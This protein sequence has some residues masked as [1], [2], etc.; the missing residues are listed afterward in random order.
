[1]LR[2]RG[3]TLVELIL[4][5]GMMLTIIVL[6]TLMLG[7]S[8]QAFNQTQVQAENQR[9]VR[10]FFN[11]VENEVSLA[12]YAELKRELPESFNESMRY[13]YI[14]N[15]QLMQK[16]PGIPPTV[17]M[18]GLNH[19]DMESELNMVCLEDNILRIE[20][21]R[22]TEDSTFNLNKEIHLLNLLG[23]IQGDTEGTVFAYHFNSDSK[24]MTS[25]SILKEHQIESVQNNW[26]INN[27]RINANIL[28]TEIWIALPSGIS[29]DDLIFTFSTTGS[30]VTIDGLKQESGVSSVD[31]SAE[32]ARPNYLVHAHDGS[33]KEYTLSYSILDNPPPEAR[34]VRISTLGRGYV[35]INEPVEGRYIYTSNGNGV[36]GDS[37][38]TWIIADDENGSNQSVIINESNLLTIPSLEAYNVEARKFI[39][40][41]VTP[42]ASNGNEGLPV[43]SDFV[44]IYPDLSPLWMKITDDIFFLNLDDDGRAQY[45]EN[46]KEDNPS[47]PDYEDD[48]L[49]M[50]RHDFNI[51]RGEGFP[52]G[53]NDIKFD[54]NFDDPDNPSLSVQGNRT[55]NSSAF[56]IDIG[57]FL[58]SQGL[59]NENYSLE[60]EAELKAGDPLI[61]S[62]WGLL[63]N[64]QRTITSS[65][66]FR[67]RDSGYTFQFDP[68]LSGTGG[69][70]D[71]FV[72]RAMRD[73]VHLNGEY[74]IQS[75]NTYL[76]NYLMNDAFRRGKIAEN[77]I[78]IG[79]GDRD[80]VHTDH[81]GKTYSTKLYVYDQPNR[82][83][84]LGAKT[85][86]VREDREETPWSNTMWF[87][88][89]GTIQCPNTNNTYHGNVL[90]PNTVMGSHNNEW[91][92]ILGFRIWQNAGDRRYHVKFH[93]IT[94]GK[95]INEK[96]TIESAKFLSPDI[97]AVEF[98]Q[99]I[100]DSVNL[101][102]GDEKKIFLSSD[103]IDILEAHRSIKNPK[104]LWLFLSEVPDDF[105]DVRVTIENSAVSHLWAGSQIENGVNFPVD[106]G[107]KIST[108]SSYYNISNNNRSIDISGGSTQDGANVI[109]WTKHNGDNQKW[110]FIPTG[111]E[112]IFFIESKSAEGKYLRG[113]H[114]DIIEIYNIKGPN[115][116]KFRNLDTFKWEINGGQIKNL[117]F[118]KYLAIENHWWHGNRLRLLDTS[119]NWTIEQ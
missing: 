96:L 79:W 37:L 46:R 112:N 93:N 22:K 35:W 38:Y 58:E 88:H 115:S 87:G 106:A 26:N 74:G 30:E 10:N 97:I 62:G 5:A 113:R 24:E 86:R 85:R 3:L 110:R 55:H 65:N 78:L 63:V 21:S 56:T 44:E 29:R 75:R 61:A 12:S 67:A 59:S 100:Q 31:L 13:L 69:N 108:L 70:D 82:G 2:K 47:L 40:L 101:G 49:V 99:E 72:I 76:A 36:E 43:R 4:T 51:Y 81:F 28:G 50:I 8:T 105:D 9:D 116:D 90:S 103:S 92:N 66:E 104:T 52:P 34:R 77:N 98:D 84:I 60:L 27:D 39:A 73:S 68:G 41:E 32:H 14:E 11:L 117:H 25:F 107:Q 54:V 83:L 57:R 45:N 19:I 15:N 42:I 16:L 18:T 48:V 7:V 119:F 53:N 20:I 23:Q 95:G 91:G 109:Q 118:S 94:L 71:G 6:A 89:E 102:E 17:L 80:D 111:E 64:G 33:T 114:D 1:M